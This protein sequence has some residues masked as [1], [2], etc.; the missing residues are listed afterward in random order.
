MTIEQLVKIICD[1]LNLNCKIKTH[2]DCIKPL[3]DISEGNIYTRKNL[4]ISVYS[5]DDSTNYSRN[6]YIKDIYNY[7]NLNFD[8][9]LFT[10]LD[11]IIKHIFNYKEPV[12]I[13]TVKKC[14]NRVRQEITSNLDFN[15]ILDMKDLIKTVVKDKYYST[16]FFIVKH[17]E[18][19]KKEYCPISTKFK[20]YKFGN[21][22]YKR[23]LDVVTID[24]FDDLSSL[25]CRSEGAQRHTKETKNREIDLQKAISYALY[26]WE[27][28]YNN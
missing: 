21:E 20:E 17:Y 28:Y 7:E 3:V 1:E 24:I 27:D 9:E 15:E 4:S 26:F 25:H 5:S 18:C 14:A 11:T 22:R 19:R 23:S 12:H 10:A 8:R 13:E 2:D 6:Q 16:L